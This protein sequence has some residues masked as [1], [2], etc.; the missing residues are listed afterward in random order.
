VIAGGAFNSVQANSAA[1]AVT[2]NG[3]AR[4]NTDGSLDQNFNPSANGV[5]NVLIAAPNEQVIAGG[6]FTTMQP[7]G[8]GTVFTR[9]NIV[10]INTD[11]SVDADY[12]PNANGAVT[13]LALQ[14]DGSVLVG[15][16]F[17]TLQPAGTPSAVARHNL[18][19]INSNGSLDLNFNPDL[20][21]AVSALASRPDGSVLIGGRFTAI[22][23]NG[24]ILI[25]GNFVTVGGVPARNLASLN[26]DGSVNANFQPRPDGAVNAIL[27]QPDGK[28]VVGGA[29]ANIAGAARSRIARFNADGTLDAAFNPGLGSDP[30]SAL[31]LLPD[32]RIMVSG[33]TPPRGT[34]IDRTFARLNANGSVDSTFTFNAVE[35]QSGG[36]LV[37][38]GDGSVIAVVQD[39]RTADGFVKLDGPTNQPFSPAGLP[40]FPPGSVRSLAAQADGRIIVAGSFTQ[41][42]LRL[43]ADGSLDSSFTVPVNGPVTSVALQ[44]DGRVMMGGGFTSVAGQSRVGVGRL[45]PMDAATQSLG[46][47]A[48]RTSVIW[49]R[50]GTSAELSAVIFEISSDRFTWTRL[51]EGTRV[52]SSGSNWQLAGVTLPPSGIFYIR[53]RGIA[54]SSGGRS[55]GIFEAVRE[56]NFA[57]PIAE[58]SGVIAQAVTPA[59]AAFPA[60]TLDP[61]TGIAA[62]STVMMVPGE[63]SVE[64]LAGLAGTADK[65]NSS[66]LANLSTRGR[67]SADSPLILGFAIS[68]R[69]SRPVLV[70]AIGPAL[71]A[72]GVNNALSATRLDV[73]NDGGVLI[74]SN[75]GWGGDPTLLQAAT[76]TGAFPLTSGSADSAALLTLA[77]GNYTIQVIDVNRGGGVALAEIYDAGSGVGSRLV[78]VSSRGASG[79]GGDALISGFVIAGTDAA[80]RVLLRGVGPGLIQFGATNVVV[81]PSIALF[82]AEGRA[83]GTND[84]WVSSLD[85]ISSAAL[86]AGAFA[87]DRG[88]RDAAVLATLPSGAYTIQVS[89]GSTGTALLEIY[90]VR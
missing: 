66:R 90:E 34:V 15:G 31:A 6:S 72:F 17:T 83:L 53:A 71:R 76:A 60:F 39:G 68:G 11:G 19:R 42:I 12:D 86:R 7:G 65:A 69:D 16:T 27:V 28:V 49:N 30:V 58:A 26:D 63:G 56:F 23:L 21:G 80:Q 48:N 4:F 20:N 51:G 59:S 29:F 37:V 64:I 46:V 88:S 25:G 22:Q 2:R 44:P 3:I 79:S 45:A 81:D 43:N 87:L 57:N 52:P 82:D 62:R 14:S 24:S 73:Y 33:S 78:N 40:A 9:N 18:A 75:E 70:R 36:P 47:A 85:T 61:I 84:N 1:T 32:G 89:A 50:G 41:R 77:P 8:A 67:V 55:S 54:P 13:T 74:S 35:F 5:V 38:R 10:R